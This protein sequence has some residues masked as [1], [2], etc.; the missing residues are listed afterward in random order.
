MKISDFKKLEQKINGQNFNQ[1]YKNINMVMLVLSIFGHFASI[2]LAYFMVSKVLS[3]AMTDNPVAVFI[4]SVIILSGLELL[5]R[6]IF[7]KFSIQYLKAK[8]FTKD[9][10]PLFILSMTIIG[11]SFYSSISGAKE[12]SSKEDAIEKDK[13]EVIV[14]Y[15]DSITKV[16]SSKTISLETE[17][18]DTKS[19][20]ETKDKE[21]T[22][23]EAIQP[24]TR[25]AKSRIKDLKDEKIVL[26][27]D[28]TKLE[29]DINNINSERDSIIQ[30][31]K[32]EI[33]AEKNDQKQDN[34]S[35]SFAFVLISTLIEIIILAGVYF[36]E[37][38]KY[39]SYEDY[40]KKLEK[41][42]NFQKW[43]NYNIV[44]D[45]IYGPDTKINDKLPSTKTISELC[46]VNGLILLNKDLTEM[47]KLF[48]SLGITRSAGSSKYIAKSKQSAQEILKAYFKID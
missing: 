6:D 47:N 24:P 25:A 31:K 39:R 42:P 35:N 10:L 17:I 44:I 32:V 36:N 20:L 28:I 33:E 26:R 5:K 19:K 38:Y 18:K 29:G 22:D 15:T 11:I 3:G 14:Q 1:G 13:K 45:V 37:Y 9:V 48:A 41:D 23:L 4:A 21:Q 27:S 40:K 8:A 30:Q 43:V 16:Y 34:S 2:F 7:D 12:F 46:K